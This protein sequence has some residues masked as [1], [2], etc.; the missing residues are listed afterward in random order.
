[1]AKLSAHG[2]EVGRIEFTN[3][4]KAYMSDGNVL[5]DSGFGWKL[6]AKIKAGLTPEQ[7][8]ERAKASHAQFLLD[9]PRHAAFREHFHSLAPLSRRWK[10]KLALEMMP[11]DPDGIWSEC[12]DSCS[13][14]IE[15]DLEDICKLCDLYADAMREVR[16]LGYTDP[17][18]RN[19]RLI[20]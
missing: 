8:F 2:A 13:D 1:M 12:C 15:A 16:A 17:I 5:K 14:N 3:Y 4:R 11:E 7:A 6:H 20:R 10:L 9:R 19:G 18:Y